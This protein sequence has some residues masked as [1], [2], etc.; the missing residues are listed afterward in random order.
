[1]R[2]R[3]GALAALIV[4]G[5][6]APVGAEPVGEASAPIVDGAR[7]TGFPEVVFL[8]NT[9]GAAC[10]AT[11]VAPRLVLTA[12]HC[13]QNVSGAQS[14]APASD[15]IVMVGSDVNR[16]QRTYRVQ[17]VRPAPGR[18]DLRDA[19][20]VAVLI[21]ATRATEV[22]R[23][24]AFDSPGGLFGQQFTAVGYGQTPTEDRNNFKISTTK[25]VQGSQGGFILVEPAVC[26]GDSGGPL[27]GPDGRIWGVASFIYSPDGGEPRCGTA[28]G[29]YNSLDGWRGFIEEAL[30]DSGTCV[31]APEVCDGID[32]DCDGELDEVCSAPGEACSRDDECVGLRCAALEG[33]DGSVCTQECNPNQP[34]IGCP[35][36]FFCSSLGLG[37]CGGLCA[38]GPLGTALIEERCERNADCASGYC[39]D[40][41]DTER[42]C[43][44]PC[45]GDSG[46]CLAGEICL[47]AAGSCGACI[48][49]DLFRGERSLGEPCEDDDQ[50]VSDRCFTDEGISYCSRSCADDEA[51][52]DGF[53]C[54]LGDCVRGPRQSIG[55]GCVDN[56]DC[57]T[58]FCATSSDRSWCSDFCTADTDCP[59]GFTC[60]MVSDT[61]SV[62][63][64]GRG[65]VGE[66]CTANE[67]CISSR[68]AMGTPAGDICTELCGPERSCAPGFQCTRIDGGRIPSLCLPPPAVED[69]GGCAA[70]GPR[71]SGF[72]VL[73]ALAAVALGLRRRRR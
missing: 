6:M 47:A 25:R 12:K 70:G 69:D 15:F 41:G 51:C 38:R 17:E 20:D 2:R 61:V 13:V 55:G 43:L 68:C 28:P 33:T 7:E 71:G 54:R 40:P 4:A 73:L 52:G 21:L 37:I 22:P 10:T 24:I 53:H 67:D 72:G 16:P 32:N 36:G 64:P 23:E 48:P 26:P 5:C 63:A 29:A 66:D 14:A 11:I 49:S 35:E 18:W 8:Y 57:G 39:L 60:T 50:C 19:S 3:L 30:E 34:A 46:Q 27:I 65:L 44:A 58:G 45:E 56:A 9:R 59:G 62:C 1:M 42:R 31:E